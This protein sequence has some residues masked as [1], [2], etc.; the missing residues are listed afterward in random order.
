MIHKLSHIKFGID[1]EV[2]AN[3]LTFTSPSASA[4]NLGAAY[5]TS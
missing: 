1:A 5:L 4:K 2:A 3:Q